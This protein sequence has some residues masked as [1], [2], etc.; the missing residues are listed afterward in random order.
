MAAIV[1]IVLILVGLACWIRAYIVLTTSNDP[2]D[3]RSRDDSSANKVT[4]NAA[5]AAYCV[6]GLIGLVFGVSLL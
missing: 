4:R 6:I 2:R 5:V 1:G 3:L